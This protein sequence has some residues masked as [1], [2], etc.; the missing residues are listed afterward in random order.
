MRQGVRIIRMNG[1]WVQ[2]RDGRAFYRTRKGGK[3]VLV[4]LPNLPHDHPDFIAAWAE[5]ARSGAPKEKPKAGS[6]AS[7][8]AAMQSSDM[9]HGWTPVYRAKITRQSGARCG[10]RHS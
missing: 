3:T 5:A 9:F 2:P 8:W 4:A 10:P 1:L 7:T 6:L